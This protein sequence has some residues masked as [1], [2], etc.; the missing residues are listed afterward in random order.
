MTLETEHLRVTYPEPLLELA[1]RAGQRG[2]VAW[3]HLAETFVDPPKGKVDLLL[4][5]HTDI[6]NGFA[7]IFPSNRI[8]IFAPPPVDGFG[9]PHM[10]E[11]L[12]LVITHELAH[13]FHEDYAEGLS[14]LFRGVFGRAP[15]EW[16]FFPGSATPGW[17][18]EGLAT[19]YESEFTQAGRVRGSFHET[20]SY[21]HLRA[22]ET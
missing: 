13:V 11:W 20:V 7:R 10:D 1:R 18:V 19:F 15:L 3:A 22:H 4:T 14:A 8:V 6:S 5:D 16:P 12:E 2:E 21:T 17:V 9:L